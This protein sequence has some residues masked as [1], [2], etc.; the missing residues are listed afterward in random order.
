MKITVR[1]DALARAACNETDVSLW[2]QADVPAGA[3]DVR[4]L[5]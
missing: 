3:P 1:P 4:F 5:G 2:P